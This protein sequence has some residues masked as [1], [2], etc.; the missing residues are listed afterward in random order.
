[1]TGKSARN[2]VNAASPWESVKCANVI[3]Y[4]ERFESPVVLPGDQHAP[5]VLF[6]FDGADDAMPEELACED[7]S[8]GPGKECKLSKALLS[9]HIHS[10]PFIFAAIVEG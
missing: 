7:S 4:R 3:P 9:V 10:I 6:D 5:W 2:D 1:L 8:T